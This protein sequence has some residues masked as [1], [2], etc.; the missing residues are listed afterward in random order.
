MSSWT[1]QDLLQQASMAVS[2]WPS[3]DLQPVANSVTLIS[4][5]RTSWSMPDVLFGNG[6]AQDQFQRRI[7]HG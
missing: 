3:T 7:M 5:T 1:I 6:T 4:Y 2:F